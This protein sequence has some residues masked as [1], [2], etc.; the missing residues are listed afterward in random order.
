MQK[1]KGKIIDA[2]PR[3]RLLIDFYNLILYIISKREVKMS[4]IA[5]YIKCLME[6]ANVSP[7]ELMKPAPLE[8]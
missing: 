1:E 4:D 2:R 6:E 3:R 8:D 7:V 5:K